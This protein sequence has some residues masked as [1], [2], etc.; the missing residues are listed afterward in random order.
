MNF[1]NLEEAIKAYEELKDKF[2]SQEARIIILD[3]NN[4]QY[5][6][7]VDKLNENITILQ[8]ENLKYLKQV[9]VKESETDFDINEEPKQK[10]QSIKELLSD[11]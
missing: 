6:K 2:E 11:W 9:P 3:N 1:E 5:E 4:K 7:E 8:R 10:I